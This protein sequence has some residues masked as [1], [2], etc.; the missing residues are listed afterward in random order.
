MASV[1]RLEPPSFAIPNGVRC[2]ALYPY[3]L[4]GESCD[5]QATPREGGGTKMKYKVNPPSF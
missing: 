1:G 4:S 3:G 2:V 5:A